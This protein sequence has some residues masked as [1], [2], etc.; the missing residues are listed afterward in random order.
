MRVLNAYVDENHEVRVMGLG[1]ISFIGGSNAWS[2][3]ELCRDHSR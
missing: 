2:C 3:W 1:V